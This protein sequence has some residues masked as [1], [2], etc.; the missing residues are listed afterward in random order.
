MNKSQ[1]IT[2]FWESFGWRAYDENS[3]P[4]YIEDNMGNEVKNEPPYI[5][6]EVQ[7]DSLGNTV[8]LSASLWDKS[9]SWKNITRKAEEIEKRLKEHG[10]VTIR[11]DN[12]YA[13]IYSSTPF[14]TRVDSQ[15]DSIRRINLNIAVE[16]LTAY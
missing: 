5:T 6:Y 8:Y 10:F 13:Y 15:S 12:G 4:E 9:F 3:V 14:A 2:Q 11:L 1:A 16:F 7:T